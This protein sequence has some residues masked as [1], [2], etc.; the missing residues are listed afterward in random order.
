MASYLHDITGNGVTVQEFIRPVVLTGDVATNPTTYADLSGLSG[1]ASVIIQL[2]T[3]HA[4]TTGTITFVE[5]DT[6][7]NGSW[8]AVASAGLIPTTAMTLTGTSDGTII[9]RTVS[10]TKRYLGATIDLDG[11][12]I[13]CGISGVV[14][15]NAKYN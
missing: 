11:A 15:G 2:G 8:T 5:S 12:T 14:I 6:A 10:S 7:A 4:D 13:S 9:K 1:P 3:I